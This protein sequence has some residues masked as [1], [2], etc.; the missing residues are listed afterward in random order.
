MRIASVNLLHGVDVRRLSRDRTRLD[1]GDV[2]LDAVAAGIAELDA[3]VVALQEDD[4]RLERS[5]RVD[6]VAWL[7]ERLGL[8]GVFGPAL[9][10]NPDVAWTEVPATSVPG[11]GLGPATA[12]YG[13]GLLSRVG[14]TD[15]LRTR[16]PGGGP[17]RRSPDASPT[18]PGPDGEPRVALSATVGDGV[19]VTTTHLSYLPWRAVSQLGHALAAAGG[20]RGPAVLIGDLNLPLWAGRVA[21]RTRG[22]AWPWPSGGPWADGR[23]GGWRHLPG[24]ATY[25][26]WSP[27]LQ[28]DQA[29]VRGVA[30][31]AAT[32]GPAGPSDHLPLVV[33]LQPGSA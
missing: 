8:E 4:C 24:L 1:A 18:R 10:G 26:S 15:V 6:Q 2:D 16:L 14:L 31:T 27:R 7:A 17:G 5:G 3:D 9:V 19:R 32:V 23:D 33:D 11:E 25:P 13:V 29:Y 20:H 22:L 28:L 21:V 30:A 12:G